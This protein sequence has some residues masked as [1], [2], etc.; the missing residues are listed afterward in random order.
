MIFSM[1]LKVRNKILK[2]F[3]ILSLV[4]IAVA[5]IAFI[6][7]LVNKAII[8][9]SDIRLP[10]FVTN[11]SFLK[12]SFAATMISICLIVVYAPLTIFCIEKFFEATQTT[13]IVFFIAFSA[14]C[15]CEGVRFLVPLFGLW[16]TFSDLL[17]LC[18][19][20][21]FAGRIIAP[22]SFVFA[23]IASGQEFRQDVERNL[24]ALIA[25]SVVL[26]IIVPLNTARISSAG[27]VTWG[28]PNL[29]LAM[30]ISLIILAFISFIINGIKQSAPEYKKLALCMLILILGYSFLIIADNFVC[31]IIGAPLLFWGTVAYLKNLHK[32]YMW[33]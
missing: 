3:F 23:A 27:A 30:R 4:C 6:I 29:F 8:P 14:G 18:G 33:K 32:L 19:R 7:A 10:N 22:M 1:T 31:I 9:P 11:F 28:F 20:I 13:E 24:T 12:Y 15:L 25:I 17:F 26:A 21:L 5:S 2:L 16:S